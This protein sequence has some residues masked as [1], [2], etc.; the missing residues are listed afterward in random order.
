MLD[1]LKK[2]ENSVGFVNNKFKSE[3]DKQKQ[4]L[5]QI[6]DRLVVCRKK[7]EVLEKLNIA[8]TFISPARFVKKYKYQDELQSQI[9]YDE[10]IQQNSNIPERRG[11]AQMYHQPDTLGKPPEAQMSFLMK[12][13]ELKN[14]LSINFSRFRPRRKH[15]FEG[16]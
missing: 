14:T 15:L 3:L 1:N 6:V 8:I 2:L 9:F 13:D 16:E 7:I 4:K 12:P 10:R 5:Q 11:P